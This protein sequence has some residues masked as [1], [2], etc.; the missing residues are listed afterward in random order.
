MRLGAGTRRPISPKSD[1]YPERHQ[2]YATDISVEA[3]AHYP[4]RTERRSAEGTSGISEETVEVKTH[5]CKF[6]VVSRG[7][8]RPE[9]G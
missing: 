5:L 2:V 1:T 9:E 4:G 6:S 8:S 7:H 3:G